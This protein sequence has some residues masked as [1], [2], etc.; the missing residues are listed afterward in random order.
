VDLHGTKW[1]SE[2]ESICTELDEKH[3]PIPKP[4]RRWKEKPKCWTEAVD[5]NRSAVIDAIRY[6]LNWNKRDSL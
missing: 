6:R 3:V 5:D 1:K 4:W 2:I